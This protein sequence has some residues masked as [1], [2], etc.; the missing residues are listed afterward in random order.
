[1]GPSPQEIAPIKRVKEE[2]SEQHKQLEESLD[3]SYFGASPLS[4][5][6][7]E[8][9]IARFYGL[10]VPLEE[11]LIPAVREHLPASFPY[12]CRRDRL[13]D[14]LRT[15]G[16]SEQE[17]KNLPRVSKD[18]LPSVGNVSET[19]GCLYVVEGSELGSSVIRR[20]LKETLDEGTL[21]ANSFY[22]DNPDETR[23]H[24]NR[25]RKL[26]NE[27]ISND[28]ELQTSIT[29]ARTTFTLFRTWFQ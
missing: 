16:W 24:W 4:R 25:F 23:D 6:R 3:R 19:L 5:E 26:F 15:L 20:R 8:Q 10:Y 17:K 29:T 21:Q 18:Q 12:R 9:L 14:D 2:T 11:R 22:R 1:M 28:T 13:G 7:F 27:R